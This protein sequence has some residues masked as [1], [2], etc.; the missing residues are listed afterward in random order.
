MPTFKPLQHIRNRWLPDYLTKN[1]PVGSS[2]W[3]T[4]QMRAGRAV[5]FDVTGIYYQTVARV[6]SYST[7]GGSEPEYYFHNPCNGP[8]CPKDYSYTRSGVWRVV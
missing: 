3:A 8:E 4:E 5:T 2:K 1:Y 6:M 7:A